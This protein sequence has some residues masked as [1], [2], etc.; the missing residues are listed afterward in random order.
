MRPADGRR[1]RVAWS[2]LSKTNSRDQTGRPALLRQ[3]SATALAF[4][5]GSIDAVVTDPPYDDMIDYSDASDLFYVWIKRAMATAQPELSI[6]SDPRGLQEKDEE[7]IV[8]KGGSGVRGPSHQAVVRPGCSPK[9]FAEA[10]RVVSD[11]GVVTIVFGHGDPEVWHRLLTAISEAGLILTGSWP[12]RTEKGG[13][14]G[15][16]NIQTTLTLAC[17][18]CADHP[19][20]GEC[21]GGRHRRPGRDRATT[22]AMGCCRV[23]AHRSAYGI[24]GPCDGGRRSIFSGPRQGRKP[25]G[26]RPIPSARTSD[27]AGSSRYQDRRVA[28]RDV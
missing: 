13:R 27:G 19:Y 11:D 21:R 23:R 3:G 24:S 4:R 5:T 17:R 14:V 1:S 6:T 15:S 10:H 25:R 7:I 16:A 2:P 12:A 26:S 28:A 18:P 22:A 8:K 9:A 20:G